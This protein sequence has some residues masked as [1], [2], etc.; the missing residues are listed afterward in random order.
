MISKEE[1][2]HLKD[3]ARAEFSE[4]ETER[5]AR[6][7]EDILGYIDTLKEADISNISEMTHSVDIKNIFRKDEAKFSF[8]S[9]IAE[10][11][12]EAFPEKE[13]DYL[14]VKSIL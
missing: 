14:K 1:I 6:D 11:L 4:K 8:G 3:L 10:E 9:S 12:I 2:E 5:L 7:L 13:G